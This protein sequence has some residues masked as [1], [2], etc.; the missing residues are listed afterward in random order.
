[1]TFWI[2]LVSK[3][4]EKSLQVPNC[5]RILAGNNSCNIQDSVCGAV[6]LDQAKIE[7]SHCIHNVVY[8]G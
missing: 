5:Y 7:S 3:N 4:Y 8:L 2:M 6:V 1:M